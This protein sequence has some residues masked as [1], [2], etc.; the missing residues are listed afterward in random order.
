MWKSDKIF[1]NIPCF[2]CLKELLLPFSGWYMS[3][4][5]VSYS[6]SISPDLTNVNDNEYKTYKTITEY[7]IVCWSRV[8]LS[9]SILMDFSKLTLLCTLLCLL[10]QKVKSDCCGG[11]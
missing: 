10:S 1:S 5:L 3:V 4:F 9:C 2:L 6:L 11:I 8:V 7:N